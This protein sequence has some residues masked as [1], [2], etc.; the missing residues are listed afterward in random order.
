M[1]MNSFA[2]TDDSMNYLSKYT[3]LVQDDI[4]FVQNKVGRWLGW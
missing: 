3:E 1:L 4:Q 2:T